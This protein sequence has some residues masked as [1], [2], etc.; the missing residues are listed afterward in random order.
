MKHPAFWTGVMLRPRS[1]VLLLEL[2]SSHCLFLPD[3]FWLLLVAAP[4]RDPVDDPV[5]MV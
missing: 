3:A 5:D 4:D 2:L 1:P